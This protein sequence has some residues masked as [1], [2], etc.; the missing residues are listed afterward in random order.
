VLEGRK[1]TS[2]VQ[3]SNMAGRF[4]SVFFLVFSHFFAR[5][6]ALGGGF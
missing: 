4:H 5:R 1:V 6:E 2:D 3:N